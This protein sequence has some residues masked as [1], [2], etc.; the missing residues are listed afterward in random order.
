M[1]T[2]ST[3]NETGSKNESALNPSSSSSEH[4]EGSSQRKFSQRILLAGKIAKFQK[5]KKAAKTLEIVV[6]VFIFCWFSF[7]FC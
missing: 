7:L 2:I 3:Q 5:E 6:G 4:S 1:N